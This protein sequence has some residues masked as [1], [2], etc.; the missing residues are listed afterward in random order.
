MVNRHT[1]TKQH[2]NDRTSSASLHNTIMTNPKLL[3]FVFY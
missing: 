2:A 1:N 3:H